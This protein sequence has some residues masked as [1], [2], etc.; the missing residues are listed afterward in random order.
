MTEAE[1]GLFLRVGC[2]D[3]SL[4]GGGVYSGENSPL[5]TTDAHRQKLLVLGDKQA[6][7]YRRYRSPKAE[8][9]P[10]QQGGTYHCL[11][12]E[13]TVTPPL[14]VPPEQPAPSKNVLYTD[15]EMW[16]RNGDNNSDQMKPA[17]TKW[18]LVEW[19]TTNVL[20]MH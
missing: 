2:M 9:R 10:R 1:A 15:D 4:D 13:E 5:T 18:K 19:R 17:M 6:T 14:E 11:A 20:V 12:A 3:H 7:V 16:Q 8:A